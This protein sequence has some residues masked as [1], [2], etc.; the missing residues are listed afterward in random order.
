MIILL[1]LDNSD[2]PQEALVEPTEQH[3]WREFPTRIF[4]DFHL[5]DPTSFDRTPVLKG[6]PSFTSQHQGESLRPSEGTT[7][8]DLALSLSLSDV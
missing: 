2:T 7:T 8:T 6:G 4:S 1:T 3:L 5:D